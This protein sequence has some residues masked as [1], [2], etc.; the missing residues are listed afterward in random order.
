M[1]ARQQAQGAQNY[2]RQVIWF[3]NASQDLPPRINEALAVI[4]EYLADVPITDAQ[5]AV[6]GFVD[7]CYAANGTRIATSDGAWAGVLDKAPAGAGGWDV[8]KHG[9]QRRTARVAGKDL[10]GGGL[11]LEAG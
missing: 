5:R 4:E 11:R 1:R 10:S 9:A 8:G 6:I 2:R 7:Q 3:V